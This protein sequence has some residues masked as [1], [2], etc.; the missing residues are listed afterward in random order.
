[1][2]KS[3]NIRDFM[4][5]HPVKIHAD[6]DLFTAVELIFSE[7]VSGICVVDAEN[8]LLG[9]L[10]EIDCMRAIISETYNNSGK[11]GSVSHFMTKDVVCCSLHDNAI[12]VAA[13]MLKAH[14]RRRPVV[15]EGK[16]VGQITF[17]QLLRM[18]SEFHKQKQN[19]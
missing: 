6:E 3:V 10:S 9:M 12:D 8:N 5:L 15:S 2:L 18:V 1:M 4:L 19:A 13:D 11:V 17:R 7:K 14:H 16:L